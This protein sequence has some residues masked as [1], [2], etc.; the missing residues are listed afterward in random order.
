MIHEVDFFLCIHS[1][2][3]F[4]KHYAGRKR[5]HLMV[6]GLGTWLPKKQLQ[7]SRMLGLKGRSLSDDGRAV[8]QK[9]KH[10]REKRMTCSLAVSEKVELKGG[11]FRPP[12]R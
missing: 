5:A 7:Q 10:C 3:E 1:S 6:E 12:S 2:Q 4:E 9:L 11:S 8:L